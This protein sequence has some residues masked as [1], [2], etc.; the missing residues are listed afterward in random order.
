[1]ASVGM[2]FYVWVYTGKIIW[3]LEGNKTYLADKHNAFKK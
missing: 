1:M 2:S 3:I